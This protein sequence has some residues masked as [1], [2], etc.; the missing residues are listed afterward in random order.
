[1]ASSTLSVTAKGITRL[2]NPVKGQADWREYRTYRLS[3]GVTICLVHDRESKTTAAAATVNVGASADPRSMPGIAHFCEH[4][5]FLGSKRYSGENDY[6]SFLAQHG[7]RSNASTSMHGTTYKFEVLAPH[8]EKAFDIFSAFFVSPLF[9]HSGTSREILAVDSEN[10]KN[11]TA[12]ERRRLQVLKDLADTNHYYSKF[13]TGNSKTMPTTTPEEV[14]HL[15]DVLL[16]FHAKHYRPDML[17]VVVAGPQSLDE[18]E[19]WT[20]PRLAEMKARP[21]PESGSSMTRAEILVEEGANEAPAYSFDELSADSSATVFRSPFRSDVQGGQWPIMITTKPVRPVRRLVMMFPLPSVHLL[22]D[23]SPVSVLSHL[24]GHEGPN[25]PFAVLQ[26]AGLL[27]SLSAGPRTSGPDFTLFQVD[28]GLTENGEKN[29]RQVVDVIIQ[30]CRLIHEATTRLPTCGG[31]AEGTVFDVQRIWAESTK[32]RALFFH[33]T[34]PGSVYELAPNLS[35]N[36]VKYGSEK[37]LSAGS[38]LN[39]TI[40]TCPLESI[41]EFSSRLTTENCIIERC[42]QSAWEEM[43]GIE[44]K[45]GSIGGIKRVTEKWYGVDYFLSSI[46]PED[47]EAWN[48]RSGKASFFNARSLLKLPRPNTFI[49]GSLEL[50]DELPEEAKSGPRIDKPIESPKLLVDEKAKR[51]WHRLDDRY[52]L[53]K[54]VIKILI[55]NASVAHEKPSDRNVW[56]PSHE[57]V[58]H[59]TI[60]SAIYSEAMAQEIYDADLAGS[61]ASL[62]LSTSGIHINCSGFSDRLGDLALKILNEFLSGDFL[63]ERFFQSAQDRVLRSLKGFFESRRADTYGVYY[64]DFLLSSLDSGIEDALLITKGATLHTTKTYFQ[65]LLQNPESSIE[66]FC[67]GNVSRKDAQTFFS[68]VC[69]AIDN[70]TS[71][72]QSSRTAWIP[73]NIERLLPRRDIELHFTSRN[74]QEENGS[75]LV[76]FQSSIPGFRGEPLSSNENLRSSSSIRLLCQILREPLFDELRTKQTIGYIVSSYY[77]V[78]HSTIP[79]TEQTYH[80]STVPI[81]YVVINV[82]SRK[83]APPEIVKRVDEFLLSF[84]KLLENMPVSEISHHKDALSAKLMK[85]TQKLGEEASRC[86][87]RI[88]RYAPEILGNKETRRNSPNLLPW[89][90]SHALAGAIRSLT[91]EDLLVTYDELMAPGKRSRIVSCVYG[92]SFPLS[93][94]FEKASSDF[95]VVNDTSRIIALRNK[96]PVYGHSG[97]NDPI[98]LSSPT[99][100]LNHMR[101]AVI[102]LATAAVVGASWCLLTSRSKK[103]TKSN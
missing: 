86:F 36:I 82:L 97:R 63:T 6:K 68:D 84:R 87:N 103:L 52:A 17:T 57:A 71:L 19:S 81:D 35:S 62:L 95:V 34:S 76:T 5:L 90:N 79:D 53:P 41:G 21:F 78:A 70:F 96:L 74:P 72:G 85:P 56:I 3:N 102:G 39:E 75:V 42:S 44:E 98:R 43:E 1:M 15:R 54:S 92:K 60:L 83:L 64:R 26:D 61:H 88:K 67:I 73:D 49:P 31:D 45:A 99:F 23:R 13:S 30:H 47:T 100:S 37:A 50:S 10:V 66:C 48:D 20:I 89:D 32:L 91:R 33:Q 69:R 9:T 24:L 93:T 77:D 27:S 11:L 8:A 25:S 7:G 40:E 58:V 38:M 101:V 14:E 94:N 59:S 80:H 29:W 22:S 28:M 4:M 55:R 65:K 51:L 16:A 46:T 12:D 2:P 18:L